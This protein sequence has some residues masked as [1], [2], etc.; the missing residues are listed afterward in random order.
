MRVAIVVLSLICIFAA[1][2]FAGPT[3]SLTLN[4]EKDFATMPT[5]E[6]ALTSFSTNPEPLWGVGWEVVLKRI[7]FG[8]TYMV[9]FFHDE[10]AA[11]NLDWNGQPLYVSYHFFGGGAFLDPFIQAGVG[12]TGR[13]LLERSG[14]SN[15]GLYL[16]LHPFVGAGLGLHLG[17]LAFGAKVDYIPFDSGIPVTNIPRYPAGNFQVNIFT[18]VTLGR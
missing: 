7:G 2:G 4:A 17:S 13:V 5:A 8:G 10:Q 1:A 16:S 6:E 12:C 9:K 14:P 3:F 15:P 11:W 18:G